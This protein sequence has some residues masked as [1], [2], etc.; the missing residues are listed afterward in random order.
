MPLVA[1]DA[2]QP[3]GIADLEPNAWH[4]L[5]HQGN[6][7]VVAGPGAGKTEFLAQRAAYL[8]ETGTCP[9]PNRVLA[10]SFKTD[11]AENLATRVR[12]R[13]DRSQ[14]NRFVSDDFRRVHQKPRRPLLAGASGRLA[15]DQAL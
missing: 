13:C 5:H 11:A 2:W 4:V 12:E 15:P 10:I 3:R 14:A 1:T 7:C 8:L 6:A 9:A